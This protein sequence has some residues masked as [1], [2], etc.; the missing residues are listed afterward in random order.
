[1]SS[2]FKS[3]ALFWYDFIVGDDWTIALGVVVATF[4]SAWLVRQ[5]VNAWWLLPV[6]TVVM[7]AS[8]LFREVKAAR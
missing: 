6:V 5:G 8:S 3:F 1:M 4:L 2:W 7:L